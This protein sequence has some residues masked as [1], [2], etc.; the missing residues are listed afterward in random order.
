[1]RISFPVDVRGMV[2]DCGSGCGWMATCV[3]VAAFVFAF[4]YLPILDGESRGTMAEDDTAAA[5]IAMANASLLD[6]DPL[7]VTVTV[8]VPVPV[9][10]QPAAPAPARRRQRYQLIVT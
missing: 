5:A 2:M 6:L 9:S 7:P 4:M 8:P 10:T 3:S 1:M